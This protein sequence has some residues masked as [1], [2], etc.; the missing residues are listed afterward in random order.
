MRQI[1]ESTQPET[2]LG[3]RLPRP[4]EKPEAPQPKPA[5]TFATGNWMPGGLRETPADTSIE[6]SGDEE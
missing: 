2:G 6:D 3:E 5:D 4:G 1:N